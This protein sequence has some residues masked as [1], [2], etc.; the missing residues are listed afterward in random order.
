[1]QSSL[2]GEAKACQYDDSQLARLRD[3]VQSGGVKSFFT[4]GKGILH[5]HGRLCIPMVGEVKRLI[6]EEAHSSRYSIHPGASK[7]Y[8]ELCGLY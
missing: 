7:M 1:M 2:V 3:R 4:D 8:Q 6:L 5:R